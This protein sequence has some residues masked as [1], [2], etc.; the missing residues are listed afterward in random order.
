MA[1]I[2][3]PTGEWSLTGAVGQRNTHVSLGAFTGGATSPIRSGG[4][5]DGVL[6]L[7]SAEDGLGTNGSRGNGLGWRQPMLAH[8]GMLGQDCDQ[9]PRPPGAVPPFDF[10]A[11]LENGITIMP[12]GCP[13]TLH[14]RSRDSI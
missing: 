13:S 3:A 10:S 7:E 6:V 1:L 9:I 11:A 14:G 8:G 4:K 12:F 2:V 5:V